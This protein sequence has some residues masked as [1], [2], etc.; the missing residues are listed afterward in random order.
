MLPQIK[1]FHQEVVAAKREVDAQPTPRW[2]T[3]TINAY[4]CIKLVGEGTY[5]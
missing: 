2:G 4:E 1:S 5:G 3:R